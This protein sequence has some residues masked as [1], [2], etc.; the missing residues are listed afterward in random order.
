[1]RRLLLIALGGLLLAS[2]GGPSDSSTETKP[3]APR[4]MMKPGGVDKPGGAPKAPSP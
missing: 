4:R 2:C 1:M 3:S